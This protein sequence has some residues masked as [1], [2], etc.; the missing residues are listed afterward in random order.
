M[1]AR[2]GGREAAGLPAPVLRV[3]SVR[4]RR[5]FGR[6]GPGAHD[7][8]VLRWRLWVGRRWP[9]VGSL[10]VVG[11]RVGLAPATTMRW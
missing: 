2:G 1:L 3:R 11:V 8:V 5:A 6:H 7:A 4:V 10:R 9:A